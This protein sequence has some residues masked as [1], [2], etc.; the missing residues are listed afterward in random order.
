MLTLSPENAVQY[1]HFDG[2]WP[3]HVPAQARMLVGG[4]SNIVIRVEPVDPR[5]DHPSIILKQS[6]EF[7]RTEMEWRS[8]RERIWIETEAMKYLNG[9]LPSGVVPRV[10]FED[11]PHYIFGMSDLGSNCDIWKLLLLEGKTNVMHSRNAGRLLGMIH[12]SGIRATESLSHHCFEDLTVFDELRI[13]PYYR[14][15]ARAHPVV[16]REISELIERMLSVDQKTFVLGDFSPKNILVNEYGELSLVD[17]ETAHWGDPAFDLGFFLTHLI[18]K[19]FRAMRLGLPT[20]EE[21]L[22]LMMEFWG[23]YRRTFLEVRDPRDLESRTVAHL[24]ACMLARVDGKSPV[25]YLSEPDQDT[26]RRLSIEALKGQ[27]GG[28]GDFF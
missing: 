13:D 24:A 27:T 18:L 9:I 5:S 8:Q 10:L 20:R 17:F 22:S 25:D 23:S 15:I 7:L 16:E 21:Y 1:L 2:H 12:D 4:V 6:A 26:V 28:L 3:A 11:R 19:F 14:T